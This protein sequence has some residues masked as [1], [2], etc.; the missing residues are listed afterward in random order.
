MIDSRGATLATTEAATARRSAAALIG[1][2]RRVEGQIQALRKMIASERDPV[3]ILTLIAQ[4]RGAL[5][6]V[7]ALV[8][9]AH[10]GDTVEAASRTSVARDR[11]RF[12]AQ[13][14]RAF[15]KWAT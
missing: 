11:D 6:A 1:R 4:L 5:H 15:R 2:L 3:E 8:L 10:L 13:V 9:E 7:A 14:V 12:V